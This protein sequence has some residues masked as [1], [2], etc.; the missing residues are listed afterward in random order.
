MKK[1]FL[2]SALKE[3]M[4]EEGNLQQVNIMRNNLMEK[5]QECRSK[6]KEN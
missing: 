4:L 2:V 5:G 1:L 3:E 6:M